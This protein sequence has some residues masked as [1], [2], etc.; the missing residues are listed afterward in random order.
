MYIDFI[1]QTS[2]SK[3]DVF[4]SMPVKETKAMRA[5]RKAVGGSERSVR[6]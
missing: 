4:Y 5:K 2:H 3:R 6:P 1:W